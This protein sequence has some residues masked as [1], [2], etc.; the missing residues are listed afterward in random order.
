MPDMRLK[1][2]TRCKRLI[3]VRTGVSLCRECEA[4]RLESRRQRRDYKSEYANRS[5]TEDKR[6]RQFYRSKEWHLTSRQYAV[7]AGHRCEEC[8]GIGTDVHHIVPVQCDEGWKRRF[9][10]DN[11]K[12]LCVRCHN[13]AHGRTFGHR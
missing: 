5:Q 1:P 13:E 11:L 10:F 8:G 2:C 9:D 12:L 3:P 7:K 4:K 6:F